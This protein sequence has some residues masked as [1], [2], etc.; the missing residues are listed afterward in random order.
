MAEES[1]RAG[2]IGLLIYNGVRRDLVE[3]RLDYLRCCRGSH[4]AQR[5]ADS[6]GGR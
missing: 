3:A 2:K 5:R 4:R 6:G 1:F